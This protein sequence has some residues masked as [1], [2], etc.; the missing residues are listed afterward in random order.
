[1]RKAEEVECFRLPFSTLVPVIDR[2]RT[3]QK[4]VPPTASA[5]RSK[6]LTRL[7][8]RPATSPV[9]ASTLLLRATPHDSGPLWVATS[10]AYDFRI[11]YTSPV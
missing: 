10:Q 6:F 5:S 2:K 9:N 11:H 4:R 8:T 3:E 7:N 1:V